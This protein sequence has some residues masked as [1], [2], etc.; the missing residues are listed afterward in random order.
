MPAFLPQSSQHLQRKR[1]LRVIQILS[2]QPCCLMPP[3]LTP[4]KVSLIQKPMRWTQDASQLQRHA[5]KASLAVLSHKLLRSM[6]TSLSRLSGRGIRGQNMQLR[7][8][9]QMR[10]A[11]R[12]PCMTNLLQGPQVPSLRIEGPMQSLLQRGSFC[13][14]AMPQT[15]MLNTRALRVRW[16]ASLPQSYLHHPSLAHMGEHSLLTK[17]A[18]QSLLL[19]RALSSQ[20]IPEACMLRT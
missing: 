13:S 19:W 16:Q 10:Q 5:A 9:Q 18:W 14:Q 3:Y 1:C 8:E 12:S 4:T 6:D 17:Q 20:A 15:S 11:S 7:P 2:M